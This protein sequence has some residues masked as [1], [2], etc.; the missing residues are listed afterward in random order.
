ML[1]YKLINIREF[2]KG[3][4]LSKEWHIRINNGLTYVF[5]IDHDQDF[6]KGFIKLNNCILE[7][8]IK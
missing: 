4:L 5:A 8:K 2:L 3:K 1:Q 7:T 6:K